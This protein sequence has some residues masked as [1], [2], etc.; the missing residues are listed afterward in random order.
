MIRINAVRFAQKNR[1]GQ[2]W[3][4]PGHDDGEGI[5]SAERRRPPS[6]TNRQKQIHVRRQAISTAWAPFS[7]PI[8]IAS[9]AASASGGRGSAGGGGAC[10]ASLTAARLRKKTLP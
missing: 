6:A 8:S 2:P 1:T 4:K 5:G 9:G 7:V 10:N 3:D